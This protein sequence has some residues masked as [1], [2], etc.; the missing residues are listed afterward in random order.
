MSSRRESIRFKAFLALLFTLLML[1]GWVMFSLVTREEGA[2]CLAEMTEAE[3]VRRGESQAGCCRDSMTELME[4]IRL[5]NELLAKKAEDL[6]EK[7]RRLRVF[8][9]E[10]DEKTERLARMRSAVEQMYQELVRQEEEAQTKIV[11]I[12]ENM[13]PED[14]A[15]RL[16]SMEEAVA[17]HVIM[18]MN[19]RKAGQILGAMSP[20]KAAR[21][22]RRISEQ[23]G[24]SAK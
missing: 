11:K 9:N 16:E 13:E 10:L 15:L 17:S 1:K 18:S 23:T 5:E 7:E 24:Q 6:D 21:I 12:Y 22:T 4:K 8:S 3:S 2:T 19:G 14:A 20:D